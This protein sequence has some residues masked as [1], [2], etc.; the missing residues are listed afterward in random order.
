MPTLLSINNYFY[1]RDGSEAIYLDH[2]RLFQSAGWNVVP[3]SMHHPENPQT[4]WSKHFVTE[5]EFGAKYS[6]AQKVARIPKVIYSLE[7]RKKLARL[8]S[9]VQPNIAHCHSIYHH[10]S[11]S[12]LG[13]LKQSGIPTVMTLHDLKIACPAYHMFND[14]GVCE[15]CTNGKLHN[16]VVN[17]CIKGSAPLSALVMI[18]AALHAALGSYAKNIDRFIAPCRFYIDKLV[19]WGW[20][21]E[22]FVHI[23]N[24]VDT[25]ALRPLGPP[26]QAL[27]YF[28]R[29]APEKG[30]LTLIRA[31]AAAKIPIRLVGDGP[32]LEAL[33]EEVRRTGAQ[34]TFAGRLSGAALQEEIAKA[35]ATVLPAESYENAPVT[36]LES[37]A[38]GRPVIGA[39]IGGIPELIQPGR[40]GWLFPS[41]S[42]EALSARLQQVAD[43]PDDEIRDMGMQARAVAEEEFSFERYHERITGLYASL[44]AVA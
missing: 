28:G 34:V 36:V 42:V 18:E 39:E 17:R 35:R 24:F 7:A 41:G 6:V 12:I 44:G 26:G 33:Q 8:L 11:P 43:T 5:I 25:G 22:R 10:I 38:L 37:Y 20:P 16:V 27:L 40:T 3:F 1:R 2:N 31:A 21:R 19:A 32:Q 9:Q 29:L 23:P 4:A 30:L 13:V 14:K 15:K